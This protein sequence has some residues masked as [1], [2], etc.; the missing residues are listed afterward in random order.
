MSLNISTT[1]KQYPKLPYQTIKDKVLGKSYQAELIFVGK[2]KAR[3]LNQ[4]SRGKNYVPNVLS[5]PLDS[6]TGEIYIAPDVA[7]VE[8]KKFNLSVDG[9]IG[10]LFIHGLLHLKGLDHGTKMDQKEKQLMKY[11][12]LK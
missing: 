6:K 4:I 7:K 5:F 8:A 9:Y 12:Q 3:A 2:A 10:Y 1:V 11:F